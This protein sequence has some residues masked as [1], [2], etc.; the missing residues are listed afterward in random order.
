[1]S[2]NKNKIM[3]IEPPFHRLFKDSYSL[4]IYPLSLGYLAGMI[5]KNTD[6]DVLVYNADFSPKGEGMKISYL[7][8]KG[9]YNYLRN[10]DNLSGNVWQ[11]IESA[12]S[13]YNPYVVGISAKSQNFKSVCIVAKIVKSLNKNS[14]VIVGGPHPSMAGSE[15]LNC[16]DIDIAII[17]EGENTIVELVDAIES[18]KP[19]SGVRGIVYR[20]GAKLVETPKRGL[21]SNLDILPFPYESAQEV[22]KDYDKYPLAAFKCILATRGCPNNCFYCGSPKIWGRELRFR[23]PQSIV[24]EIRGLQKKGLRF[25]RFSD[26]IFGINKKHLGKLCAALIKGCSGIK[27]SCDMHVNSIDEETTSM[28]KA[29]GCY[30]ISLG[31]ESGNNQI[32]KE[33]GKNITIE[34]AFLA[35]KII[36]KQG[37]ELNVFFMVGFPQETQST[38]RDTVDAMKSIKCNS[39][40]YSIFTPYPNTEAFDLCK[41]KGLIKKGYDLSLYNHQSPVNCFCNNITPKEFRTYS[42]KIEKMVDRKNSLDRIRRIFS[43]N[44]YSRIMELGISRSFMEGLKIFFDK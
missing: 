36:K 2:L 15:I 16:K 27:W 26:D 40:A 32:L 21:I 42:S 5:K 12:I 20:D 34:K 29:A 14:M 24:R 25:I 41:K 28:M 1:M 37:I 9:F 44:T 30:S 38:L 22:L 33:I 31:V 17:G 7:A 8:G 3:L 43:L 6:W 13:D 10:L 11:E 19:L 39:I 23:S 4:D 35:A 18:Q